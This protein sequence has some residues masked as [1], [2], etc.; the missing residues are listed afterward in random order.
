[1]FYYPNVLQRHSGCFATIWLAATG[2]MRL[3][4]REYLKVDVVQTCEKIL[5]YI[6]VQVQSSLPGVPRPRFSLYLSA[7]LQFGVIRVYFRQCQYLVE[8]IQHILERLHR[9]QQQIRI[10]MVDLDVPALLLPDPLITM[11]TLED[12]PDPFFGVM[13]ID[14]NLPSPLDIPQV[15]QLLEAPTP[16]RVSKETPP[17]IY[18]QPRKLDTSPIT[19]LLPETITLQEAEPIHV[20]HIEG[21]QDLPEI[22]HHDLDLLMAAEDEAILSEEKAKIY[23]PQEQLE[24]R[25][26][27]VPDAGESVEVSRVPE[28][29]ITPRVSPPPQASLASRIQEVAEP[30]LEKELVPEESESL[31]AEAGPPHSEEIPTTELLPPGMPRPLGPPVHVPSSP[32]LI[33]PE[34]SASPQPPPSRRRP[35][36][37]LYDEETQITREEFQKQVLQTQAHT[38]ACPM[39]QPSSQMKSP[40][41]L[42]RTPVYPGWLHPELLSLWTRCARVPPKELQYRPPQEPESLIEQLEERRKAETISEIEILRDIQ[43]PSGPLLPSSELSLETTEEERSRLSFIPPEER[44]GLGEVE[45]EAPVLPVVPELPEVPELPLQLA[46]DAQLLSPEALQKVITV[47]LQA[48]GQIDFNNLIPPFA[49][50]LVAARAFYLLLVLSTQQVVYVEQEEP[51]GSLLIRPGPG[52]HR[53]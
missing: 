41:E 13:T 3:V 31:I 17:Q 46:P 23:P 6:L 27:H 38:R 8:D 32:E 19:V 24:T 50:R 21:E 16:E 2:G 25:I 48:S 30:L 7:Q 15:R 34:L 42:L 20:L 52:N 1:M 11:E 49:P 47:E 36:L 35:R 43:E 9:A 40:S 33:L 14:P 44:W 51:Y 28:Q 5:Q 22:S 37:Q 39:V 45:V 12:A 18:R 10:D 29:E 53:H 4:K 26:S